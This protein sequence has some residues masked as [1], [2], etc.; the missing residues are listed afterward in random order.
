VLRR[1]LATASIAQTTAGHAF[2]RRVANESADAILGDS[3]PATE[4]DGL[5][6]SATISV[7]R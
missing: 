3:G 7:L 6:L 4:E 1:M 2:S 5:V